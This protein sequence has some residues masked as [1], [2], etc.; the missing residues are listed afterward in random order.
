[1]SNVKVAAPPVVKTAKK[2]D[3]KDKKGKKGKSGLIVLIVIVLLLAGAVTATVLNLFGLRDNVLVPFLRNVPIIGNMM[4]ADT[5]T[6]AI[7]PAV[8]IAQ[9]E[10]QLQDLEGQNASLEDNLE[11][12]NAITADL[13][14][15]INRLQEFEQQHYERV[16]AHMEF[17]RATAEADPEAFIEFFSTMYPALQ[18]EI[19]REIMGQRYNDERWENYISAWGAANPGL[20]ALSIETMITTDMPLIVSVMN[21]LPVSTRASILNALEVESRAAVLRQMDPRR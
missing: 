15:E 1:M 14:A 5:A 20:V 12:L 11:T 3:K 17:M 10:T 2:A 7:D 4:P 6:P 21:D 16:A 18:E 13:E 19:F 9:L 8:T